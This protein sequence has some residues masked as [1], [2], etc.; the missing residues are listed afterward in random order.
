MHNGWFG[1]GGMGAYWLVP[2]LIV[3]VVIIAWLL[4]TRRSRDGR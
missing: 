3:G 1:M 2:L 4:V